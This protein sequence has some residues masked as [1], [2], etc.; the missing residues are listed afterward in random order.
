M[1]SLSRLRQCSIFESRRRTTCARIE[2]TPSCSAKNLF[3]PCSF[4]PC[5]PHRYRARQ[6]RTTAMV[7]PSQLAYSVQSQSAPSLPIPHRSTLHHNRCINQSINRYRNRCIT[8]RRNKSITSLRRCMQHLLRSI[9]HHNTV[10]IITAIMIAS[11]K[12]GNIDDCPNCLHDTKQVRQAKLSA[13]FFR[14]RTLSLALQTSI[15]CDRRGDA[16]AD[17]VAPGVI[18][19]LR[20]LPTA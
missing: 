5:L 14:Q 6:W 12:K 1:L 18:S 7:W 17:R 4:L 15:S 2:R 3:P 20:V 16:L 10:T 13:L 9:S 19:M 8:R 11:T